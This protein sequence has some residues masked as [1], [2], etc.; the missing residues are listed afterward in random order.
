[1]LHEGEEVHVDAVNITKRRE[2]NSESFIFARQYENKLV[3]VH[4]LC[5]KLDVVGNINNYS[6]LYNL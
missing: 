4:G 6:C 1:M 2:L 3:F 5:C